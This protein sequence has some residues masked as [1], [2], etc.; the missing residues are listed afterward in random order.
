MWILQSPA[1]L[2]TGIEPWFSTAREWF[3]PHLPLGP[4]IPRDIFD[5]QGALVSNV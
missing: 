1:M 5:C 3:C 2:A 4:T